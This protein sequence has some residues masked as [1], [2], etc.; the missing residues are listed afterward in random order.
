MRKNA[1]RVLT[2]WSAGE[3]CSGPSIWTDGVYVYSYRMRIAVDRGHTVYVV[4]PKASPSLTTTTHIKAVIEWC[5]EVQFVEGEDAL[6]LEAMDEC[7]VGEC[8][9]AW[10]QT[11]II[12]PELGPLVVPVRV[13]LCEG[14]YQEARGRHPASQGAA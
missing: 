13:K 14:H 9:L 11:I 10:E 7:M 4:D 5:G 1:R 12:E 6:P 3:P 2:Q 8:A